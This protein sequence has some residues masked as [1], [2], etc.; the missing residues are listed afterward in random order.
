ME[1]NGGFSVNDRRGPTD[2][3]RNNEET[4]SSSAKPSSG[5]DKHPPALDFASFII[6]LATSTQ[7]NL[8]AIPHPETGKVEVNIGAAKQMIDILDMLKTKTAG[9]LTIE[10]AALLDQVLFSLSTHH[11]RVVDEQQKA[12]GT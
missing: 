12:G 3:G 6:F 8:G 10:E 2:A 4:G 11:A 7:M 9:N 1:E 5:K